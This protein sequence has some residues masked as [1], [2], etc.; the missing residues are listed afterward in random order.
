MRSNSKFAKAVGLVSTLALIGSVASCA[1]PAASDAAPAEITSITVGAPPSLSGIGIHTAVATDAFNDKVIKV[2]TAANR[3]A[4]E[5]IPQLLNDG[6]Q[7]AVTDTVTFMQ[8]RAQG[9][10]VKIIAPAAVQDT[11]GE[12]GVMAAAS[13]VAAADS[14]LKS[15][16]DLEGKRVGIPG[17]GTLTWMNIRAAID[18]SGADSS[19]VD[20]IEIPPAQTIELVTQG[21]VDA[22][23][24]NEP[25]ASS[26]IAGGSVKLVQNTD[27]PGNKGV[28]TVVYVATEKFISEHPDAIRSFSESILANGKTVNEDRDAALKVATEE[29]KFDPKMVK[30]AFVQRQGESAIKPAELDKISEVAVRYGILDE[31]PNPEDLLANL[32]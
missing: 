15:A 32:G 14:D 19:K 6:I 4:N 11:N 28:P 30:N 17:L 16:A 24:P 21:E 5:A 9:L 13:V 7:I 12:P 8:A 18:A 29:L 31:A 26:A 22:A 20:F 23:T 27:A 10:P 25:L 2:S 1:A 3:S